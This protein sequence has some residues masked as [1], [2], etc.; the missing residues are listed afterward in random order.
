MKLFIASAFT[1]GVL[2]AFLIAIML[3]IMYFAGFIDVYLLF[4]LTILINFFMWLIGPFISDWMYRFFYKIQWI[5]IEDL[6]KKSGKSAEIIEKVCNKYGFNIPKLGIIPDNNPN[7]FTYG[8]GRWNGRVVA[9]EGIFKYLDDNEAAAVY[10]HELGHIKNRDFITLTIA[11]TLLQLLYEAYVV[12]R[13]IALSASRGRGKKGGGALPFLAIMAAAYALYWIGQYVVL[14]LSRIREYCA[15]EFAAMETNANHLSSALIKIAYGILVNP[16]DVRLVK[17]TKYIGIA[18]FKMAESVGLVYYNS[19]KLK[20]WEPFNK[21]LLYDLKNPWAFVAELGSTHPLTGKRLR[22][23]STFSDSPMFDFKKIEERIHVDKHRLY[24]G[25]LK[26][27]AVTMLPALLAIGFPVIYLLS[28]YY[29]YAEF[30]LKILGGWW[31]SLIGISVIMATLYKYP[32]GEPKA[33]IVMDLMSDVYASPV[34]GKPVRLEG[35]LIGKGVPGLIFSEDMVMQ[36]R[37]GLMFLNYESWF[38][39]F[40]NLLFGISKVSKLL[41]MNAEISG[42]FTRGMSPIVGLRRLKTE[43]DFVKGYVRAGGLIGGVVLIAAGLY[44][45][46][47]W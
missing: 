31:L 8:S 43:T 47:I 13:R 30:S 16:D 34:R 12:S 29:G 17:S 3:S 41:N 7:A 45:L 2:A 39:F 21:T 10:A 20:D 5:S 44:V 24:S 36:D 46:Y 28:A 35:K 6:R 9:T 18:D 40:G 42:W 22:R 26:D 14:Y 37:T 25:F 1:L 4:G 11:S 23:L 27:V 32:G 15:D 38:P 19:L 33:A